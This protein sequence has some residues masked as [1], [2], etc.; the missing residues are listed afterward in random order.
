[1]ATIYADNIYQFLCELAEAAEAHQNAVILDRIEF[2]R[3]HYLFP[4]T[5]EFLGVSM[6]VLGEVLDHSKEMLSPQQV[7]QA[8]EY[9]TT[10]K[11][12]FFS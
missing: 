8:G 7:R 12:R 1:M 9:I 2:A 4:L 10:I 5:S 11:K 6:V 3:K